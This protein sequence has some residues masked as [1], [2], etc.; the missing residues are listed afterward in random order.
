MSVLEVTNITIYK[1]CDFEQDFQLTDDSGQFINLTGCEVVAKIR[2]HSTAKTFNTF[3]INYVNRATGLI[4][5]SMSSTS[6][7]FLKE[8]RNYFDI[9]VIFPNSKIKPVVKGTIFVE[10]TS[11]SV[12]TDGKSI[13]DLG[14]V[15]TENIEDGEVLMYNQEEQQLEF[16]NPD[17]VLIKATEGGLPDAFVD[18]IDKELD[19][20]FDIDSGEY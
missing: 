7:G 17:E 3:Y 6:S 15:D 4:R 5:L 20:N 8:G 18:E 10:E 2:K 13:G 12:F 16:V 9:L 11:S 1:G 14:K 19:D